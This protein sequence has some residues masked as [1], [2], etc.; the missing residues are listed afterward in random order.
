MLD[1]VE[2]TGY[3][4]P[5]PREK[6]LKILV[7]AIQPKKSHTFRSGKTGGWKEY[8]TEEHKSLFKEM[9]GDLLVRLGYET[10]ND[11]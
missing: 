4:I 6:A 10:T 5:T 9:A 7:E 1:E 11:W 3:R 8:F 2:K